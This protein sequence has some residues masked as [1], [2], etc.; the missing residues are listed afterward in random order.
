MPGIVGFIDRQP[1]GGSEQLVRQ[2]ATALEP[3]DGY[4]VDLYHE[5]EIGLGRVSL[6]Y[7]NSGPQPV[8]NAAKTCCILMEGELFD[9]QPLKQDLIGRGHQFHTGN[10][11]ELILNLYQEF[12][13]EFASRLNG[14]FILAIWDRATKQLSIINDRLGLHPLYY[15]HGKEGLYFGSGVRALLVNPSLPRRIDYTAIAEFLTFDHVLQDRTYLEDVRL[16]PQGSIMTF[17]DHGLSIQR[18]YEIH[19]AN[20]YALHDEVEYMDEYNRLLAQAIARQTWDDL[21]AGIFLS[22]GLDSRQLLAYLCNAAN[23]STFYSFT[24]GIP[25]CDD[26]RAARELAAKTCVRHKFFELKPDWLL[27]K[28]E[29]GVRI[30]DGMANLINLHAMATLDEEVRYAKV[31][32]KGFLGDAM[33]GFAL[34]PQFWANYDEPTRIQ[35]HLKVHSGQGVLMYTTDQFKTLLDEPFQQAL[36]SSLMDD[37]KAGMDEAG[38]PQ[39][40]DQRVYFDFRQ[41]VPRMTLKGVEVVRSKMVVRLPFADNDLVEFSL[42]LPPGLRYGRRLQKNAFINAFPHLAQVPSTN[43]GLPMMACWRDVYLRGMQTLRWHLNARGMGWVAGPERRPY[44]DYNL[45]FRTA[46]RGWVEDTLLSPRTTERGYFKPEAVRRLV[47]EHMSGANHAVRIGALLSLEL[48]HR[49]FMD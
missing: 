21:P 40:A 42:R 48:W 32:Y 43:T 35:A 25:N 33:M 29:E 14:A 36:G 19:Y 7:V 12:G 16:M 27:D 18:Y 46:L 1:A 49:Q 24:W 23:K 8:W 47:T 10:D 9:T 30:T 11:P 45:W 2:M 15:S 13:T 31:V 26:A 44:K 39:L 17:S 3:A 37:Y 20:P 6:D 5:A 4:C 34:Q 38:T 41:R 22:G 28:A